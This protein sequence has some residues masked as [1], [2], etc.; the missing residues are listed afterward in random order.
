MRRT[1]ALHVRQ[2]LIGYLALFV[3]LGGT[4]YAALRLPANS[5]GTKQIKDRAVT[6]TKIGAGA[7]AAL[8]GRQ[9]IAGPPGPA[10]GAAGGDLTGNYPNPTI[11]PGKVT[12][13]AFAT[14][15][16]APNAAT[17]AGA[18]PSDYGAVLSGRIDSLQTS[19][20]TSWFGSLSGIST[21]SGTSGAVSTLSPNHALTA[22]DLSVQ[23]TQA[24]G[25]NASRKF[26]LVIN[27]TAV[28]TIACVVSGLATSCNTGTAT[29]AVPASS[30]IELEEVI[31]SPTALT[32]PA[33]ADGL[34]AVRLTP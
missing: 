9:G 30:T 14:G 13:A 11:A 27:G 23:L 7:R 10:T 21:A 22:R 6:L 2:H 16:E 29:A 32:A 3:A 5:V 4:S 26:L 34:V 31:G 8:R 12:S 18:A 17:L 20:A 19:I 24:P 33:P 15:A 1:L 28:G 25:A